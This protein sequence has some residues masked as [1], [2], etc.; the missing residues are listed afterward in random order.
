MI[1]PSTKKILVADDEDIENEEFDDTDELE[2]DV[3]S[4]INKR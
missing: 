4:D 2:D 3:D 1:N